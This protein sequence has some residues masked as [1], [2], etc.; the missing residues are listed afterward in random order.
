[1][2]ECS[3]TSFDILC[4]AFLLRLHK[5]PLYFP[6]DITH[7][8]TGQWS[9]TTYLGYAPLPPSMLAQKTACKM[10]SSDS[11]P[12]Y[13]F[14]SAANAF[15][16]HFGISKSFRISGQGSSRCWDP[17]RQTLDTKG[18]CTGPHMPSLLS[19]RFPS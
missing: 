2:R 1:M 4:F 15:P 6:H 11:T 19:S 7:T 5:G 13:Q 16:S 12:G 14:S 18:R 9:F 10:S 17:H 8:S 3:S